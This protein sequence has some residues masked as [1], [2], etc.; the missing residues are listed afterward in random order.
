MDF[1]R[2]NKS[3]TDGIVTAIEPGVARLQVPLATT[4]PPI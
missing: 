4:I 1:K 3:Q 2:K